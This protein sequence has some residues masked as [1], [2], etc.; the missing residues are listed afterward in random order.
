[1]EDDAA[2]GVTV[3]GDRSAALVMRPGVVAAAAA[4]R[5]DENV[6]DG[7]GRDDVTHRMLST[8]EGVADTAANDTVLLAVTKVVPMTEIGGVDV[9]INVVDVCAGS[10]ATD[11]GASVV[12]VV[13]AERLIAITKLVLVTR[14][15][16]V[17]M[18]V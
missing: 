3:V 16:S 7:T 17:M 2:S 14:T 10:A 11:T 18:P 9:A 13:V 12:W 1:V 5:E 15:V 4:T 8:P 6:D